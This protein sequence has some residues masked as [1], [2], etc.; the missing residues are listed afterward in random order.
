MSKLVKEA[1]SAWPHLQVLQ[2]PGV[3]GGEEVCLRLI[4]WVIPLTVGEFKVLKGSNGTNPAGLR[5]WQV[6]LEN[7]Q[8]PNRKK[9]DKRCFGD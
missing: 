4:L 1:I 7:I 5:G 3:T 6:V 9:I 2:V 8:K